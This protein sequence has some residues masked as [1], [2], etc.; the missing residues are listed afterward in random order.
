MGAGI[1][2]LEFLFSSQE[3]NWI[4]AVKKCRMRFILIRKAEA[5]AHFQKRKL[6]KRRVNPADVKR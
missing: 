5:A 3:S 4:K 2:C 6:D 1:S